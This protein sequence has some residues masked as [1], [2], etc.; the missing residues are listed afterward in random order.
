MWMRHALFLIVGGLIGFYVAPTET[1][2]TMPASPPTFTQYMNVNDCGIYIGRGATGGT[3]TIS[4]WTIKNVEF[5][6]CIDGEPQYTAFTNSTI[7]LSK[8]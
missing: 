3:I 1:V 8:P 5:G 6:V 2:V 7:E 4:D